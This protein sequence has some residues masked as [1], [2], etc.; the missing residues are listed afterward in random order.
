MGGHALVR[1]GRQGL[2]GDGFDGRIGGS[3]GIVE[4]PEFR[5]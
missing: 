5:D 4:R 2:F 3:N 1:G